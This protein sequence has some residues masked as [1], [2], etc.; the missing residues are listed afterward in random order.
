MMAGTE[1]GG[2]R[3][4][5][6]AA[7]LLAAIYLAVLATAW[8]MNLPLGHDGI[9]RD[10]HTGAAGG[11]GGFI[12]QEIAPGSPA[13]HVGLRPGDLVLAINGVAVTSEEFHQAVHDRRTGDPEGLRVRRLSAGPDAPVEDITL[14]LVPRLAIPALA[15]DLLTVSAVGLL[16]VLVGV[17]V[18]LARATQLPARLL[19]IFSGG[20]ATMVLWDAVHWGMPQASVALALDDVAMVFWLLGFAALLHL[21]LAFPT[22]HPWFVR[23]RRIAFPRALPI[24][25]AVGG[26]TALLYAVSVGVPI[27]GLVA[28]GS[29]WFLAS[30]VTFTLLVATVTAL[31]QGYRHAPTAVARAQLRWIF[32]SVVV[33][34]VV[35][36]FTML[37]PT[38]T[39]GR[40]RLLPPA[41]LTATLALFP[42]SIGVAI[43]RYRLFDI[44]IIFSRTLVYSALTAVVVAI[45]VLVVGYLGAALHTT[46]N[47]GISLFATGLVALLFQPARERLQRGVNRLLYGERDEPYAVIARLG[48]RLEATLAPEAVLPT[49]VESVAQALRLPHTSLWL[50]E[51]GTLRVAAVHGA[52]FEEAVIRDADAVAQLHASAD[53]LSREQLPA[54]GE[55]RATVERL[56]V[57]LVLPLRHHGELV[58]ALC[59][60]PRGTHESFSTGDRRLLRDLAGQAGAAIHALRLTLALQASLEDLRGSRQRLVGA[61]EEERRRIQRDLHDGLGPTLASLRLRLETCVDLAQGGSPDL[62]RE[63]E[64]FHDLV[65]EATAEIRRL[66]YDLRPPG[67]DQLGLVQALRQHIERFSRETGLA[68]R[69]QVRPQLV[70]PPAAEVAL[71]RVAQ[72]ALVNV[73]KHAHASRVDVQLAQERE[74]LMLEIR[75]DG[76]GLSRAD[77]LTGTG[78]QSMRERADL[79]GGTLDVLTPASAGTHLVLRIPVSG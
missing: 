58:G 70:V 50:I 25:P 27:L 52:N 68:V 53:G 63:L 34:V 42:I 65:G 9:L 22:P 76:V 75:D 64:R 61:Q 14:T 12:V 77:V 69:F 21:F 54:N 18:A 33:F 13:D 71:F 36:L 19:L 72:E 8:T 37:V 10:H 59:L 26:G 67:L 62:V 2:P 79:L 28:T 56:G 49:I 74:S 29:L 1:S 17:G 16:T 66:V 48:H 24:L 5:R 41:A 4:V 47:L 20:F 44:D 30:L 31:I 45:Y 6:A 11:P 51:D 32:W 38:T 23:L 3:V 39:A 15:L 57:D 46:D 40:V 35:L 60:A 7:L 78:L 43:L 55:Y 73:Q